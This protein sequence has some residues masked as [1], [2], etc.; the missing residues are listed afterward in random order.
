M[1]STT[2]P[3][4][5]D[6]DPTD[7][8]LLSKEPVIGRIYAKLALLKLSTADSFLRPCCIQSASRSRAMVA[9]GLIGPVD[10]VEKFDN[11][12]LS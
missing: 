3:K 2:E 9:F 5:E 4:P 12:Y 8:P 1:T 10:T 6:Y 7:L 11:R